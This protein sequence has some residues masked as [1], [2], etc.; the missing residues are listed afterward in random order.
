MFSEEGNWD[1]WISHFENVTA[2]NAWD[3]DST[4]LKWLKVCLTGRAQQAFQQFTE[5]SQGIIQPHEEGIAGAF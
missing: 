1:E 5:E 3:G 4:K 2:V